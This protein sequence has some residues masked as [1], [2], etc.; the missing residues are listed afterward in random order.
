MTPREDEAIAEQAAAWWGRRGDA[1][2]DVR[3]A[4]AAWLDADPR[5]G[6]A[7]DAVAVA[8]DAFD[9]DKDEGALE[10]AGIVHA[11]NEA[12]QKRLSRG[13]M[14]RRVLIGTGIAASLAAGAIWIGGA[15][16]RDVEFSTGTGQRLTER[17]ED[18]STLDL[19]ANTRVRLHFAHARRKI[20]LVQGRALFDVAHDASK[21]FSVETQDGTVTD[22]GT[23]FS[24]EYRD[25]Q[26]S[27]VLFRGRVR[28]VDSA[29]SHQ[30]FDLKPGDA[31]HMGGIG[32][33]QLQS[34]TDLS[35]ALLWRD[36]RLVFDNQ[37]LAEVV[38]RM[39]D[40]SGRPIRISDP[41]LGHLRING[42]FQAGHDEAFLNALRTYYGLTVTRTGAAVVIGSGRPKA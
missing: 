40:Y 22:L 25:A 18:G 24:V 19:D 16:R 32:K 3:A 21:P 12:R 42:I 33:V 28:A 17:L 27:V 36:G 20:Y 26:T 4:F 7:F 10:E 29:S 14:V 15:V 39:N 41:A 13:T 30:S 2:A 38:E 1:G 9:D 34:N 6:A 37:S 35:R 11:L 5:H 8:W 31:L 23:A